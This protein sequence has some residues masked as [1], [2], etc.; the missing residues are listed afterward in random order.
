MPVQVRRGKWV[1]RSL[2][3]IFACPKWENRRL[4]DSRGSNNGGG[5]VSLAVT[6]CHPKYSQT[7]KGVV[8][9]KSSFSTLNLY[10]WIKRANCFVSYKGGK[11]LQKKF[12][13]TGIAH[14]PF[15]LYLS[16]LPIGFRL[17]PWVALRILT[18]TI[19]SSFCTPGIIAAVPF[20]SSH[21]PPQW[22]SALT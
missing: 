13:A 1:C 7:R 11:Q 3:E 12:R 16:R 15:E 10:A 22:L 6:F 18:A 5:I 2:H 4:R 20:F 8:I 21:L 19:R 9:S 17:Y 14:F